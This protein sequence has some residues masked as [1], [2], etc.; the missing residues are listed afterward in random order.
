[1]FSIDVRG[2]TFHIVSH[3]KCWIEVNGVAKPVQLS[4]G[5]FVVMPRSDSHI[6]RD[7]P[8]TPVVI[9]ST[10][11]R[12][13]LRTTKGRLAQVARDRSRDGCVEGCDLRMARP[14]LFLRFFR[15]LSISRGE[16]KTP[17]RGS[18]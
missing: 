15:L 11:S 9:I 7:F 18:E 13:A 8:T 2:P 17:H 16:A 10:F 1:G 12:A 6:V 14:T 4:A 5:D 3:G